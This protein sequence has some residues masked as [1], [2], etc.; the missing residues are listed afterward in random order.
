M[1]PPGKR[2]TGILKRRKSWWRKHN[3]DPFP[4]IGQKLV[5]VPHTPPLSPWSPSPPSL[6]IQGLC[7]LMPL[8]TPASYTYTTQH[9]ATLWAMG[10]DQGASLCLWSWCH[11]DLL[12]HSAQKGRDEMGRSSTM[13]QVTFIR[14]SNRAKQ[15]QAYRPGDVSRQWEA[16]RRQ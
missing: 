2:L 1:R 12:C 10:C 3:L 11:A 15:L 13:H 6:A 5:A 8:T 7:N 14:I 9:R 4:E 16:V